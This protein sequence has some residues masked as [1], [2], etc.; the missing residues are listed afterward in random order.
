MQ[1]KKEKRKEKKRKEGRKKKKLKGGKK[2]GD[3]FVV[4]MIV[5]R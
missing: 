2:R 3:G 5:K 4:S 1:K